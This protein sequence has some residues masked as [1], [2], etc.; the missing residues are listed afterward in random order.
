MEYQILLKK[1][2]GSEW[3][4]AAAGLMST[5][6]VHRQLRALHEQCPTGRAMA[7]NVYAGKPYFAI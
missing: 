7:V 5:D 4:I 6:E 1:D 3:A 2:S